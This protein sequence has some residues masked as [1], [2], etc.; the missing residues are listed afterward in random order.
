MKECAQVTNFSPGKDS[1]ERVLKKNLELIEDTVAVVVIRM[2]KD[3]TVESSWSKC[4]VSDVAFMERCFG[5]D[6]LD[7][8]NTNKYED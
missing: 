4:R 7:L 1:S 6:V 5:A 2:R 8:I 3:R